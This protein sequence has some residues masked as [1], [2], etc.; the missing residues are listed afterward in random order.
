MNF[1]NDKMEA[2]ANELGLK[3]ELELELRLSFDTNAK[4]VDPKVDVDCER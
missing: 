4:N 1:D 3:L 2:C